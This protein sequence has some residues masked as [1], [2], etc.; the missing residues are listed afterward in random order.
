MFEVDKD[1]A[2]RLSALND[3]QYI[4]SPDGRI[5][6][7]Y[8]PLEGIAYVED[9]EPPP[10]SKEETQRRL[11]ENW[12]TTEEVLARLKSLEREQS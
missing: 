10:M 7:H 5:L 8:V 4:C 3:S 11:S 2:N 6:G 12:F 1:T 9:L